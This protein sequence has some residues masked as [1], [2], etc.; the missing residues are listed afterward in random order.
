MK[1]RLT[2]LAMALATL[3]A[4]CSGD[5]AG[6]GV[7]SLEVDDTVAAAD[8]AAPSTSTTEAAEAGVDQEQAMLDFAACMR[9]NGIEMSDPS[10]DSD[11]NVQF[12]SLRS[13]VEGDVDRDAME[14]ARE[15]CIGDL[16]GVGLTFRENRDRTGEQDAFLEFAICMRDNGF[17]MPDPDFSNTGPGGDG[18]GPFGEIDLEDPDFIAAMEPCRAFLAGT[19]PSGQGPP[20]LGG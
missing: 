6:D 3:V 9:E 10:V 8:T 19:G 1:R 18:K 17:D 16:E 4:A 15:A 7:A 5:S 2:V 13:L 12:G 11:G 14:A 20:G